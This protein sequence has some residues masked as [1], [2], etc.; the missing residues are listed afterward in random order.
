MGGV[1]A[2]APRIDGR[3]AGAEGAAGK[4]MPGN[5]VPRLQLAGGLRR[6][7]IT[8]ALTRR[9]GPMRNGLRPGSWRGARTRGARTRGTGPM[10]RG[11]CVRGAGA[12]RARAEPVR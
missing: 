7:S 12:G 9:A 11:I 3:R 8:G 4:H 5:A 1:I 2:R 10:T 6:G